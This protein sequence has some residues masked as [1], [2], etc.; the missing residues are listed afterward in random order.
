M[1]ETIAKIE[2]TDTQVKGIGRKHLYIIKATKGKFLICYD[3]PN[4]PEEDKRAAFNLAQ[5]TRSC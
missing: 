4:T 1:R 3:R 5:L 2:L